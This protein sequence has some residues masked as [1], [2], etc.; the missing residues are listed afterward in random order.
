ML[1]NVKKWFFTWKI[2]FYEYFCKQKIQKMYFLYIEPVTPMYIYGPG[3]VLQGLEMAIIGFVRPGQGNW[4]ALLAFSMM[5]KNTLC[6]AIFLQIMYFQ[7]LVLVNIFVKNVLHVT[8]CVIKIFAKTCTVK[9]MPFFHAYLQFM[10]SYGVTSTWK[11]MYPDPKNCLARCCKNPLYVV[12]SNNHDFET[13]K[14]QNATFFIFYSRNLKIDKFHFLNFHILRFFIIF[15]KN[16]I[17]N[18][19]QIV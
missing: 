15:L 1:H 3:H 2:N 12:I 7:L 6:K 9:P 10:T 16:F 17:K 5:L 13:K 19:R 14:S 11:S 8:K 4:L 18:S